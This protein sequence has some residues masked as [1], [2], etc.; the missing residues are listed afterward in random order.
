MQEVWEFYKTTHDMA[1]VAYQIVAF[2]LV[3]VSSVFLGGMVINAI[4]NTIETAT[5]MNNDI[6][7]EKP[8]NDHLCLDD[9]PKRTPLI[10]IEDGEF[11]EDL[12]L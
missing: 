6:P 4:V 2:G 8:K 12:Q 5:H 3:I 1:P 7:L 11:S 10:L 9:K